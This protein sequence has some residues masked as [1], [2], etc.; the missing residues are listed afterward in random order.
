[1]I[2]R[3]DDQK[4]ALVI[5]KDKVEMVPFG[6]KEELMDLGIPVPKMK[7][8]QKM[9]KKEKIKKL[10]R[11]LKKLHKRLMSEILNNTMKEMGR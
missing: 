6:N 1:M 8:K 9:K 4:L 5:T 3:D 7:V 2:I 10:K 11:K